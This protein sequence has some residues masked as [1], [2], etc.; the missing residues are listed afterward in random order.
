MQK[1]VGYA[2]WDATPSQGLTFQTHKFTFI[3]V[4]SGLSMKFQ[5]EDIVSGQFIIAGK[6]AA[7]TIKQLP[8]F[9]PRR[10]KPDGSAWSAGVKGEPQIT[11]LGTFARWITLFDP[12]EEME[13]KLLLIAPKPGDDKAMEL[14]ITGEVPA[15]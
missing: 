2:T 6:S 14:T 15:S 1:I 8:T 11:I 10:P 5:P 9:V 3:D 13:D 7:N 12:S 4:V